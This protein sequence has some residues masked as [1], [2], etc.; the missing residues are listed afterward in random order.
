[1]PVF[2]LKFHDSLLLVI[3]HTVLFCSAPEG[4][5][6]T[7][8]RDLVSQGKLRHDVYQENVASELDSLLGR[9][10]RYEMEMEDYHVSCRRLCVH[11]VRVA[12]GA[13]FVYSWRLVRGV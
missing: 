1:M 8:Y 5:P 4:G 2:C 7:L 9:L 12:L 13:F 6:L 3:S 10:E 11:W